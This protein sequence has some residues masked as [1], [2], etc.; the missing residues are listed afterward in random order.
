[1]GIFTKEEKASIAFA[2]IDAGLK[3]FDDYRE[4]SKIKRKKDIEDGKIDISEYNRVCG[5]LEDHQEMIYNLISDTELNS[6][7]RR[8]EEIFVSIIKIIMFDLEFD[9][10]EVIENL[11]KF[12]DNEDFINGHDI[13][14]KKREER[15]DDEYVK[16]L[17]EYEIEVDEYKLRLEERKSKGFFSKLFSEEI[18]KPIRPERR[19]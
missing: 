1:M 11:N 2:G 8:T 13:A 6:N 17:K 16:L 7:L 18:V 5:E 4:T 3:L 14:V 19:H 12:I 15:L 9:N 10:L